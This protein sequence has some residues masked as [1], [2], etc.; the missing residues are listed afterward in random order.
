V[1]DFDQVDVAELPMYDE[2]G[3]HKPPTYLATSSV[4]IVFP[5]RVKANQ[6]S[7]YLFFY[8]NPNATAPSYPTDLRVR[9]DAPGV[10][11]ENDSYFF[12]LHGLNGMLDEVSLKSKPEYKFVHKKETNGAIQWNPGCYAPPR[13]WAHLSDWEPGKY[14]YDYEEDRG[15]IV[16]H[17]RRWGM[18][19]TMPE[20]ACSMT[21]KFFAGVPYFTMQ[22]TVHVRFDVA[23]QALR[24]AEIVFARESFS[25][26][27]WFDPI[28]KRIE[29][30]HITS[31]P[32]L[33]EWVMPEETPWIAF[34]D[35]E[36][37]CGYAG[38][39][40]MHAN[41]G[42]N[43][44]IRTLN[45]YL[46]VTTGPWV[47]VTRA[48]L[49]PYGSRNP[50]QMVKVLAGS[51]FLEEWA[52][53]PFELSEDKGN[54]FREV[55]DWREVLTNPL[56]VHIEEPIDQRMQVPEEIYIEPDKTGWEE[57]KVKE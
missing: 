51:V 38:I 23:V 6:S 13:P 52:Y 44:R 16:Y 39:Q 5:A 7:L 43:G 19:P 56:M 55:E 14:D 3:K 36:K 9:G 53:L 26:A 1:L 15:P 48:L 30:R 45:P 32:D 28:T 10:T 27:A 17:T 35:R 33:T 24:N 22:S 29:T 25:E 49:Y 40:R 21:Y 31:A 41:G 2:H 42:L 47:Y 57:E 20:L 4:T 12:K 50:Q 54:L 46:Y 34:F 37:G 18:M 11:V 8:G